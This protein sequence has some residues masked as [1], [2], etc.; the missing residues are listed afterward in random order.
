M[1][2]K[3]IGSVDLENGVVGGELFADG[4]EVDSNASY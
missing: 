2:G 3:L 1:I 4:V